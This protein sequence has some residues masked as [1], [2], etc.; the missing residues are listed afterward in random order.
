MATR[1]SI[2]A[3]GSPW[4]ESLAG[5]SPWDCKSDTNDGLNN[6]KPILSPATLS[7]R[8]KSCLS[9]AFYRPYTPF[10]TKPKKSK[11]HFKILHGSSGPALPKSFLISWS[12]V[13]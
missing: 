9:G 1:S 4:T 7:S 6:K 13:S 10:S 8:L 11:F 2:L 12:A 3:W 5:Y